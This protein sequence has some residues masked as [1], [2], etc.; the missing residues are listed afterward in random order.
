M[1]LRLLGLL[2]SALLSA[3]PSLADCPL[4]LGHGTGLV[5]FS[6]GYMLAFRPDP[7]RIEAGDSFA[8]I[9]NV[10]TR[11]GD[12]AELVAVEATTPQRAAAVRPTSIVSA[13]QGRF[14]VE[15]LLLPVK[16]NW[17][18]A[19]DV[20]SGGEIERLTHDIVLK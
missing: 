8:L 10:C 17:E 1:T 14:R 4:D 19:F 5:I 7:P 9:M 2:T 12:A 3:T 18:V 20:R 15:G 16:G 6:E 11:K 13:G